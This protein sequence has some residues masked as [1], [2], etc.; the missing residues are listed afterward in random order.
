MSEKLVRGVNEVYEETWSKVKVNGKE[1]KSFRTI[2]GLQ[3]KFLKQ[4]L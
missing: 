2:N 1:S 4:L 3:L